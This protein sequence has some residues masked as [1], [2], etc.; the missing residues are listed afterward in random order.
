MQ[1][2]VMTE[3]DMMD[4]EEVKKALKEKCLELADLQIR[5]KENK[6]PVLI[7]VEGWGTAGKGTLISNMVKELDPRFYQVIPGRERT[8]EEQ[9][10]PFLWKY[11]EHI[12]EAG[13][14]VFLDSTW[15]TELCFELVHKKVTED[16]ITHRLEEIRTAERQLRE[17]GY[18]LLKYFLQIDKKDQEKRIE[19]LLSKKDTKWRVSEKDKDQLDKHKKYEKNFDYLMSA[20]STGENPW[21]LID[22]KDKKRAELLVLA[23]VADSIKDALIRGKENAPLMEGKFALRQMPKVSEVKLDQTMTKEEYQVFLKAC[24]KRLRELHNQI[25]R[26][27]IPV[28][29]A[30]EG[31]DAAG[32]GGNIKRLSSALD[33]RGYQVYP[34]AAPEP[35]ELSRFYLWRF[36]HRLPKTGHI[37]IFDRT[38]YGRVMVERI[39]GLCTENEWKRAYHEINEFEKMLTDW[40]AIV[41]KFWIQIDKDTQLKRFEERQNT[42]SKQWKL[43]D[44]DW[45]NREKWDVYEEAI[46]E[47]IQKTSTETAPW[48]IVASNNKYFARI[49][50][51]QK[52]IESMEQALEQRK[53]QDKNK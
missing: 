32:K 14:I 53:K 6:L 52:T 42:P 49:Q 45:R 18:L 4:S 43:T 40:G 27:K 10:K 15:L 12:P 17:N 11:M 9:R 8:E 23:S 7:I 29:I 50:V 47:M 46:D 13:K 30:Y 28:V 1:N 44:E 35:H 34:I 22:G 20:S 31:W 5:L 33:A 41:L 2:T 38:W 51:L 26:A 48:T 16:A 24:Q 37:S 36:W 3:V 39:E 25:Y 21:N 19:T